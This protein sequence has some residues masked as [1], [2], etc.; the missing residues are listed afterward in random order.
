MPTTGGTSE[1]VRLLVCRVG[2]K[3]C[4]FSIEQLIETMR[5][6]PTEPLAHLPDFVSG[7]AV[8]RGQPTPVLDARTLLGISSSEAPGRYLTLELTSGSGRV[9]ALAV[10]SILGLRD[11]PARQLSELPN[12]LRAPDRD[13]FGAIAPVEAELLLLLESARLMPDEL[14][15][16][17]ERERASA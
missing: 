12:L 16:R 4:A 17:I 8:I 15:R 14:W 7:V 1:V 2:T 11:V 10:D 13:V 9:V 5:P 3:L 6:L